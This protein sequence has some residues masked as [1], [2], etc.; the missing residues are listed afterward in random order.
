M[1]PLFNLIA[2][3]PQIILKQMNLLCRGLMSWREKSWLICI[4]PYM[5]L[6][7]SI[8]GRGRH[9]WEPHIAIQGTCILY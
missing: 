4:L 2:T 5:T 3:Y 7:H 8:F 9:I 6:S 1:G